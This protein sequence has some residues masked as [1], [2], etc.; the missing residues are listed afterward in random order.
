MLCVVCSDRF[1]GHHSFSLLL[2]RVV[3]SC[4]HV[5]LTVPYP[6]TL[7][8]KSSEASHQHSFA[9]G[10]H[11]ASDPSPTLLPSQQPSNIPSS[12]PLSVPYNTTT[13]ILS[14]SHSAT[15]QLV[16]HDP[17]SF[18]YSTTSSTHSAFHSATSQMPFITHPASHA[19]SHPAP[20]QFSIQHPLNFPF[21]N[22][23]ACH[24]SPTQLEPTLL[25]I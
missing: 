16:I 7:T 3:F 5:L 14:A 24:P 8:G 1:L 4:F 22:H 18:L 19:A 17:S 6:R 2:F 10:T 9:F 12:I 25:S 15:S 23:P 21:N 11:P 13:S 20:T